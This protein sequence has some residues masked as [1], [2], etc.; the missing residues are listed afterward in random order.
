[1]DLTPD[2]LKN[3]AESVV[4]SKEETPDQNLY[5]TVT[6]N[7]TQPRILSIRFDG[8][9]NVTN[10]ENSTIPTSPS[11]LRVGDRVLVL[12]KNHTATLVGNLTNPE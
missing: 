10:I 1:M 3:F 11:S 6:M 2:I 4:S 9:T 12:V 7:I 8:A 5:A